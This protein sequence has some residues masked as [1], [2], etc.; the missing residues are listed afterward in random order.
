MRRF[1]MLLAAPCAVSM[2]LLGA[3]VSVA[4]AQAGNLPMTGQTPAYQADKNDGIVGP[5]DVPDDGTL[6]RGATLHYKVRDDGTIQNLN[7]R[8]I[9]EVKCSG[10]CG[11]LHDVNN[12]YSWSGD[13]TQETI[14]DWLE[15]INAEGGTG[16]AGHNDWR[17]PNVRELQSIVDYGFDPS[18]DPIFG[19]A[20]FLY[21]SSTSFASDPASA[22]VVSFF[23]GNVFFDDKRDTFQMRA[24]RGGPK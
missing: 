6:Q 15:D 9:W 10:G 5:V 12:L 3:L 19:P 24:V 4:P 16:Y 20:A 17:I 13:G 2:L 21:W 8:L 14:W 18:I 7:T 22:W 1:V 11:G 23:I